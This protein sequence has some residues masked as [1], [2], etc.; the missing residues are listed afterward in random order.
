MNLNFIYNKYLL[1]LLSLIIF[2]FILSCAD[3][4]PVTLGGDPKIYKLQDSN[5]YFTD[6]ISIYGENLGK[7]RDS[8]YLV[9]NDT[10][11]ISSLNC[12]KWTNSNIQ[13]V[14]PK[15]PFASKFFVVIDGKKLFFAADKYYHNLNI[16]P[17]PPISLILVPS[18][19]F[20]MGT[21]QFGI[22]N[23]APVHSVQLTQSFY[24]SK[25]EITQRLYN[26]VI[27]NNPSDV[28]GNEFPVYN[29][30]WLEAIKFCNILSKIDGLDT[31]YTITSNNNYVSFDTTA[32]GWR[33]PTEAEWEYFAQI[34]LN[35]SDSLNY[36]A[37]FSINSGLQVHNVGKL[38]P[39]SLG[40]YDVLGNVWEWCWDYYKD[41][42]Y[43]ISPVVNPT[44]PLSGTERVMRG[45]SYQDS[46]LFVR[47]H[48]RAANTA[49]PKVG[50]RVV[51]NNKQ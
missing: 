7:S 50:F 37:W 43:S 29:I 34:N 41:D 40:L 33:L 47:T 18:G 51:K 2:I 19:S 20:K 23:E 5:T 17:Y 8:S 24:V 25:Y 38:M 14:V 1:S 13:F 31:V 16:N 9:F 27:G 15:L 3:S 42:Y 6:T 4:N 46:K 44:G 12:L 39:N 22:K 36:F 21:E 35:D 11:R 10:F 26:L 49:K 30:T 28:T 32:N 48:C 45:G